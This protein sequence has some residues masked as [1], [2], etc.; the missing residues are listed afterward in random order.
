MKN[1]V[2]EA[3]SEAE[4]MRITEIIKRF[5]LEENLIIK[6]APQAQACPTDVSCV[7]KNGDHSINIQKEGLHAGLLILIDEEKPSVLANN[8]GNCFIDAYSKFIGIGFE[9]TMVIVCFKGHRYNADFS[10]EE[11]STKP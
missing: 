5:R 1:Y 3:E 9:D 4:R 8:C 11:P 7:I 10:D 6:H 2:I